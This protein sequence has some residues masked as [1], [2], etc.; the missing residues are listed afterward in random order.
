MTENFRDILEKLPEKKVD[1]QKFN[2]VFQ[3]D[4]IPLWYFLEPLMKAPQIPKPFRSLE[5]IEKDIKEDK[6]PSSLDDLK[7]LILRKG[8]PFDEK[9]KVWL[10]NVK[11]KK[12]RE[13]GVADILFLAY[14]N[15]IF[16]KNGQLEFL[17]FGDVINDLKKR[18]VGPLVLVCDPISRNSLFRLKKF[19]NLLYSHIDSEIIKESKRMSQEL[20][21]KWKKVDKK[22]LFTHH[23]K[24]YWK[25]LESEMDFLFSREILGAMI[26]YYLTFKKIIKKYDVK[27]IYLTDII[28]IYESALFG[29][30]CKLDKKILYSPHGYGGYAVPLYIR[31][32]FYRKL[33]F[34]TSGDEERKKLLK[35]GIKREDI[36]VTG[37][38][39]FDKIAKWKKMK[40]KKAKNTITLLTQPLVE[41][42]YT[43]EKEYFD[44]LRKFLAQ[45]NDVENVSKIIVKL[46]PRETHKS[47]Y[48]SIAKSLGLRNTNITQELGKDALY[49]ILSDSD[50]LISYGSTTDIEGLMLDK[51][52]IVIN[53]LAKGPLAE[54]GKKDEYREVVLEIDKNDNLTG[55]ITKILTDEDL[56]EELRQKRR[57]Y[58]ADSFYKIDGKAHERVADLILRLIAES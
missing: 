29:A 26:K 6:T 47:R 27:L 28:G 32:E 37:S 40:I 18:D 5:D 21:K 16:E 7:L 52:V 58:L 25:F 42:K 3:I 57:K 13:S 50:L 8:L 46:H 20:A 34:A 51:D 17:G 24:N 1:S 10:S 39:F 4:G 53:G 14:T 45:I 36:F 56:Q 48:E 15:Q 31:E 2:E 41:D 43:D 33:I 30:A 38:P 19:E 11:R 49:S 12:S 35:L 55:M 23:G 9:L 22:S 44:Y 54:L